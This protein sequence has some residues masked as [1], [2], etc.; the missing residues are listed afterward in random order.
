MASLVGVALVALHEAGH[1]LVA[2]AYGIPSRVA[3]GSRYFLPV[4]HA[5]VTRAWALP[6]RERIAV[7]LAG[8]AVNLAILGALVSLPT[9]LGPRLDPLVRFSLYANLFQIGYQF[10]VFL[11]TDLYLALVA[12]TREWNL[13]DD[14]RALLLHRLRSLRARLR[15]TPPPPRPDTAPHRQAALAAYAA[16]LAIGT[17][18]ML[19][20]TALAVRYVFLEGIAQALGEVATAHAA[21]DALG[22]ALAVAAA[23]YLVAM[24]VLLAR[25]MLG[26]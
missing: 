24:L 22:A 26:K 6:R 16:L 14:A 13:H 17:P 5:D 1:L 7:F 12:A 25:G 10:L 8:I 4:A 2:R 19:V 3:L 21:G 20:L 23:G 15:G 11:R 9:N 18:A